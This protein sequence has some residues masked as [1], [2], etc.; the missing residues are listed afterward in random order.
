MKPIL[1]LHVLMLVGPA[2]GFS[3]QQLGDAEGQAE[4][5]NRRLL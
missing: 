2:F 3:H 5:G 1:S 4:K